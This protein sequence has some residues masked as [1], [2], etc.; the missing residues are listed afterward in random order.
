MADAAERMQTLRR[1]GRRSAARNVGQA[2]TG[3]E[4]GPEAR[5]GLEE[6]LFAS[7]L[8]LSDLE[9][10][11]LVISDH[12]RSGRSVATDKPIAPVTPR[13]VAPPAAARRPPVT[14]RSLWKFNV[15]EANLRVCV[16]HSLFADNQRRNLIA[17]DWL[18]LQLIKTPQLS[19][20][21]R[22]THVL[23]FERYEPDKAGLS[24]QLWGKRYANLMHGRMHAVDRPFSLE[25]L[26]LSKPYSQQGKISPERIAMEDEHA[27]LTAIGTLN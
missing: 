24:L 19:M 10:L 1:E 23:E 9:E 8:S 26:G 27:V 2:I 4:F 5:P 3:F 6:D 18:L 22:I 11:A 21:R 17:H 16:G 15:S 7:R 12:A 25:D 20:H 13:M 14:Q